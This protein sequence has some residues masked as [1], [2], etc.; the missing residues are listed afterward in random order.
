MVFLLSII[1]WMIILYDAIC[2][3]TCN[4][5]CVQTNISIKCPPTLSWDISFIGVHVIALEA[6]LVWIIVPVCMF[7][8]IIFVGARSPQIHNYLTYILY[9]YLII[10]KCA[11]LQKYFHVIIYIVLPYE[12]LYIIVGS[13]QALMKISI[14]LRG[15]I[16]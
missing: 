7:N 12:V 9:R 14:Q 16:L 13:C 4:I 11:K 5:F 2:A 6:C 8:I 15:K 1:M 3:P 10:K